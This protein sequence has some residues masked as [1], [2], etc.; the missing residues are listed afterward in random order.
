MDSVGSDAGGCNPMNINYQTVDGNLI[1]NTEDLDSYAD[2]L[3]RGVVRFN[4]DIYK[5]Y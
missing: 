3:H 4:K 1:V 2:N 5:T